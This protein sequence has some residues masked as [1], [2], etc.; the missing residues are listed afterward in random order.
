MQR[1]E[2]TKKVEQIEKVSQSPEQITQNINDVTTK[3][4]FIN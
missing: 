2:I 4:L 1:N 3:S